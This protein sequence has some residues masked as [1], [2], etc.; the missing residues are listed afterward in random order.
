MKIW[1]RTGGGVV[2][3]LVLLYCGDYCFLR[4]RITCPKIGKGLDSVQMERLY[5]I[6][7]KSGKLE[8]D[9]DPQQPAQT[10]PCAR[11]LFPHMGYQ[12]CWYL[13]RQSDK[14]ILMTIIPAA[15][16]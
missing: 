12:T 8:Y 16:P 4:L 9:F 2:L 1:K 13:K 7:L 3:L 14:P 15:R 5:A 11:S 10:V 6:P